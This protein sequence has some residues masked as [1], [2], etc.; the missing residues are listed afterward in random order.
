MSHQVRRVVTGYDAQGKLTVTSDEAM[1]GFRSPAGEA[2]AIWMMPQ[3]PI[4]LTQGEAAIGEAGA[5]WYF[6]KVPPDSERA[7]NSD[8]LAPGQLHE[9]DSVDLVMVASGEIWL[10]LA[11][12]AEWIHL[13]T[14]ATL[15]QR[16]TKH[17]WHNLSDKDAMMSCVNFRAARGPESPSLLED[18]DL[19]FHGS[20][21]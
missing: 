6:V 20:A 13:P 17:A 5:R 2:C 8:D 16:G 15:V 12:R 7:A 9:N 1:Q 3:A 14:G 10:E 4:A 19:V 11:G 21:S 18:G